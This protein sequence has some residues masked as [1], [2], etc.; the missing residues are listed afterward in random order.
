VE[1]RTKKQYKSSNR[2]RN[3][4]L[5]LKQALLLTLIIGPVLIFFECCRRHTDFNEALYPVKIAGKF[6]YAD[7]R[8]RIVIEPKFDSCDL[9]YFGRALVIKNGFRNYIN[10][11]GVIQ[12]QDSYLYGLP[13]SSGLALVGKGENEFFI[14]THC[15]KILPRYSEVYGM[16]SPEFSEG[17]TF[18]GFEDQN[19]C[20]I[21]QKGE[22]IIKT[23]YMNAKNFKDGF[24]SLWDEKG[25]VI[26][27]KNGKVIFSDNRNEFSEG[28][29]AG[30]HNGS[31]VFFDEN[32]KI[33][34]IPKSQN[35]NYRSFKNGY[36]RVMS[37]QKKLGFINKE[38]ILSVPQIYDEVKDYQ[39]GYAAV[40]I[41]GK[42]GFVDT[43][44]AQ[45]I[46]LN[47]DWV[48]YDGFIGNFARVIKN[49]KTGYIDI[50]GKFVWID[51]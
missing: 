15:N 12:C 17:L 8:W 25:V 31:S 51:K 7:E 34:L 14:D 22:V 2:S 20:F 32:G 48:Y 37:T 27:N 42:W 46:P 43:S 47:F 33:A 18:A 39:N 1:M 35:G 41:N 19:L 49:K 29:I 21:N 38:G 40:S 45:V 6:G 36:C 26:I 30:D 44:G 3:L 9:F 5:S 11:L 50:D 13:F 10:K 24:A 23:N 4:N 28:V 16:C